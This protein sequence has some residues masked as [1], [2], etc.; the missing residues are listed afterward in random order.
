MDPL[1]F[2]IENSQQLSNPYE[3]ESRFNT[4]L[5]HLLVVHNI[6]CQQF[7]DWG[8]WRHGC[9]QMSLVFTPYPY[10]MIGFPDFLLFSTCSMP[11]PWN[12]CYM[13]L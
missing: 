5:R 4:N 9:I 11:S 10:F 3:Q 12:V 1:L 6:L 13:G 2:Q 7:V 8:V